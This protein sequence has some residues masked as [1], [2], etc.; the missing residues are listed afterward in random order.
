VTVISPKQ[1]LI[2]FMK[3]LALLPDGKKRDFIV[4]IIRASDIDQFVQMHP[5]REYYR[6]IDEWIYLT[7]KSEHVVNAYCV[8]RDYGEIYLQISESCDDYQNMGE[9]IQ[10]LG[11]KW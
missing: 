10:E 2:R 8:F 1:Y 7:P 4:K 6:L 9:I 11:G 5:D 3:D